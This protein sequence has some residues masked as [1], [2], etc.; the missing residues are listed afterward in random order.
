MKKIELQNIT[1]LEYCN[2]LRSGV[3]KESIEE[4]NSLLSESLGNIG[5]GMDLNIFM[6]Q[7]DLLIYQ[8]KLALAIFE[9][10]NEKAKFFEKKIEQQRKELDKK[11]KKQEKPNLYNSFLAWILAVEKYL[12]F[13]IDKN[14]DLLYFSEATKQMLNHY[15][16]QKQN[17]DNN[18]VKKNKTL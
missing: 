3:D 5:N 14:N 13:A 4:I 17:I 10:D 1:I 7:K 16:A 12:C 2:M 11:I 18:K 6:M 15:E 9:F 8:C